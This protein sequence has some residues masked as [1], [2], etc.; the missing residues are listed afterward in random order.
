[1]LKYTSAKQLSFTEF[2][3]P[4]EMNANKFLCLH[5][6]TAFSLGYSVISKNVASG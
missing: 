5:I 2:Q 3:T 6:L 4:F 1:M